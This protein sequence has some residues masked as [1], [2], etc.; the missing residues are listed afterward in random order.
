MNQDSTK[1]NLK[2]KRKSHIGKIF[3]FWC[4]ILMVFVGIFAIFWNF[5]LATFDFVYNGGYGINVSVKKVD[6][7]KTSSKTKY[8]E[9]SKA[10]AALKAKLNPL[11]NKVIFLRY[12]NKYTD[13]YSLTSYSVVT[14]QAAKNTY[15][16]LKNFISAAEQ[17]G[18]L[19]FLDNN[20]NDLLVDK[21]GNKPS[22]TPISDV[23]SS[24]SASSNKKNNNAPIITL[25]L[26]S[27]GSSTWKQVTKNNF[28]IWVDIPY[29]LDK[30]RDV[31][32]FSQIQALR[33]IAI[34]NH[35]SSSAKQIFSFSF[36]KGKQ[37]IIQ[38]LLQIPSPKEF[39]ADYKHFNNWK[40]KIPVADLNNPNDSQT[41]S[42]GM[43]PNLKKD[44]GNKYID[45]SIRTSLTSFYNNKT[46]NKKHRLDK[47]VL[48]LNQPKSTKTNNSNVI[49]MDNLSDAKT[50][51]NLI[52]GSLQG[53]KFQVISSFLINP[54]LTNV[55]LILALVLLLA[56]LIIVFGFLIYQYRIF[57]FLAALSIIV[58]TAITYMLC[59]ILFVQVGPAVILA[60][61]IIWV[62]LLGSCINLFENYK[63]EH[64]KNNLSQKVSFKL[65]NKKTILST[66]DYHVILF[67]FSLILFWVG[68]DTLKLFSISIVV[69]VISSFVFS[70]LINRIC[71]YLLIK[72][73]LIN[74]K[75]KSFF[76]IREKMLNFNVVKFLKQKTKKQK[77]QIQKK[78]SVL[79]R[80]QVLYKIKFDHFKLFLKEKKQK[81]F[82][83]VVSLFTIGAVVVSVVFGF[84]FSIA[85]SNSYDYFINSRS[86]NLNIA[87]DNLKNILND[88]EKTNHVNLDFNVYKLISNS[89]NKSNDYNLVV[90]TN[91]TSSNSSYKL[92]QFLTLQKNLKLIN[93]DSFDIKYYKNHAFTFSNIFIKMLI[94]IASTIGFIFIYISIRFNWAQFIGVLGS[95]L[96]ALFL[97]VIIFLAFHLTITFNVILALGG[98][99]L[100]C[101]AL[102]AIVCEKINYEKKRFNLKQF[103]P[104]FEKFNYYR[105]NFKTI[106][107]Q[108]KIMYKKELLAII[109]NKENY[110]NKSFKIQKKLIKQKIAQ[111][112]IVNSNKLIKLKNDYQS[113]Y[114]NSQL[115]YLKGIHKNIINETINKIY[116]LSFIFGI[117]ILILSICGLTSYSFGILTFVGIVASL[118]STTFIL[119][120]LWEK[121]DK[122]NL[123]LRC[124]LRY[125]FKYK[126]FILDEEDVEGTNI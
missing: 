43:D 105:K 74:K 73:N 95:C 92:N 120:S 19:Y 62:L 8:Y 28:N 110:T 80:K 68:G 22:R 23:V 76:S 97:S 115:N 84:N 87:Q 83:V 29:Y 50:T 103:Y 30:I 52:N 118:F 66:I 79:N 1:H 26:N 71:S 114:Q 82:L 21:S 117:I 65:A 53:I 3:T 100:Y 91:I 6:Q 123:L 40:W 4:I 121:L 9:G 124:R 113:N 38:N 78:V 94:V 75:K 98:V 108:K 109:N 55:D 101:L 106:Q 41:L 2:Q 13:N 37:T 48:A 116:L 64:F 56:F 33:T 39:K 122:Y 17:P 31:S 12:T 18:F 47:Y 93:C 102:S 88:Y 85:T 20:G 36:D 14:A 81:L 63:K 72:F 67:I 126:K 60:M 54:L 42:F 61:L 89:A 24:S 27:K 32:S 49:S 90:F 58:S 77:N 35:W 59:S 45:N 96:F 7:T 10:T 46:I 125:F 107:K 34:S 15:K 112:K 44:V 16:S 69:A 70:I 119:T 51:S 5:E 25:N 86:I 104:I 99:F 111:L 57:G 11:D